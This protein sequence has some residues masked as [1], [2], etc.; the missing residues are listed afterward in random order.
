MTEIPSNLP[1]TGPDALDDETLY[2]DLVGQTAKIGWSEIERFFAKGQIL[3]IAPSLDLVEVAFAMIRDR[4]EP[5]AAWQ[6]AGDL[7]A[8]DT[9]TARRWA[10]GDVTLW[11]VVTP[12]WILVQETDEA[13]ARH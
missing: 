3:R 9:D 8:L 4:T 6:E 11:A 1:E 13:P 10:G 5:V 7:A 2:A 12:P